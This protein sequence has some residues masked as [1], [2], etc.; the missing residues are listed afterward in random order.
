LI[1]SEALNKSK[2]SV[3]DDSDMKSLRSNMM[4]IIIT[5][6][7][8]GRMVD[9]NPERLYHEHCNMLNKKERSIISLWMNY[10]KRVCSLMSSDGHYDEFAY[11]NTTKL[12]KSH[13]PVVDYPIS[14]NKN[15]S[16]HTKEVLGMFKARCELNQE[17]RSFPVGPIVIDAYFN[18]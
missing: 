1:I 14:E 2:L 11:A 9:D 3:S 8:F 10:S 17:T 16:M 12:I 4:D 15:M 13:Y 7:K 6:Y 18:I 5:I